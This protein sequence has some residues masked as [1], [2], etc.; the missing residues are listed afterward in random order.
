MISFVPSQV[1]HETLRLQ[2]LIGSKTDD[3]LSS[4]NKRKAESLTQD[5]AFLVYL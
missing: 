1:H 5:S 2:L 4:L 3:T